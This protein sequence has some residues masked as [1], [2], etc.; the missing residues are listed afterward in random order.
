MILRERRNRKKE[1]R[2]NLH[3]RAFPRIAANAIALM[4]RHLGPKRAE[5][6][7]VK[8]NETNVARTIMLTTLATTTGSQITEPITGTQK[9]TTVN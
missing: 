4:K 8:T 2:T 5:K 7:V 9:M 6:T 3:Q 1:K